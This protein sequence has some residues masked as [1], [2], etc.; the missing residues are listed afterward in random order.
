[1]GP[2]EMA[3][4]VAGMGL[5]LAIINK[6]VDAVLFHIVKGRNSR[7]GCENTKTD[8]AL[9]EV[10]K[11]LHEVAAGQREIV[12][13]LECLCDLQDDIKDMIMRH[14]ERV[15]ERFNAVHRRLDAGRG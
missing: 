13:R 10:A 6:L 9:L 2:A 14:E 4:L 7:P 5:A 1:M 15:E 8:Q 3:G 12:L 11:K